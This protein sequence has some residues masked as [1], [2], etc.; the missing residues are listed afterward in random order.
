M[1][2]HTWAINLCLRTIFK[3]WSPLKS[4][5]TWDYMKYRFLTCERLLW[6]SILNNVILWMSHCSMS[7]GNDWERTEL[8]GKSQW[9]KVLCRPTACTSF[10]RDIRQCLIHCMPHWYHPALATKRTCQIPERNGNIILPRH[11]LVSKGKSWQ[12]GLKDLF[13]IALC[14]LL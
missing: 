3:E 10:V 7:N 8:L 12:G 5:S 2:L 14:Y 9:C 13:S 1:I 11:L 4:D 6:L